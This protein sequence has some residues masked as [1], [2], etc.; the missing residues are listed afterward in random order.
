MFSAFPQLPLELREEIWRYCLPY[1]VR[2]LDRSEYD[3]YEVEG[4]SEIPCWL[5]HITSMNTRPPAIWSVCHEA[6]R[7][8]QETGRVS[9]PFSLRPADS[10]W[11][12]YLQIHD[13]W[14]DSQRDSVHMN[15]PAMTTYDDDGYG[16]PLR[17]LSFDAL[18]LSGKA[19]IMF[20]FLHSCLKPDP[21]EKVAI[22]AH[23]PSPGGCYPHEDGMAHLR[24]YR[25]AMLSDTRALRHLDNWSVVMK[26]VVIHQDI[27]IAAMTGLFGLL[28]DALVQIVDVDEVERMADLLRL[29]RNCE[30]G[31]NVTARQDF[32]PL[33]LQEVN[34]AVKQTLIERGYGDMVPKVRPAVLFRLCPRMCNRLGRAVTPPPRPI[35]MGRGF[36]S[37]W[38]DNPKARR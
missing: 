17:A 16:M 7:V 21:G 12:S 31:F 30:Q 33:N 25:R 34:E 15:W 9:D 35:G 26:T 22:F 28:G 36:V 5:H 2:E 19:S 1:R 10:K 27:R 13:R 6:R 18:R 23:P 38:L 20:T 4:E 11:Y 24:V 8:A 29:A 37:F 14:E 3:L 32:E